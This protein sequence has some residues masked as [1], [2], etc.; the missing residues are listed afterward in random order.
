LK[1]RFRETPRSRRKNSRIANLKSEDTTLGLGNSFQS[2][3]MQMSINDR[4][5]EIVYAVLEEPTI[6]FRDLPLS[7]GGRHDNPANEIIAGKIVEALRT[8]NLLPQ[9]HGAGELHKQAY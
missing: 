3:A 8:A 2:E 6:D 1:G 5:L 4:A 7:I 9:N